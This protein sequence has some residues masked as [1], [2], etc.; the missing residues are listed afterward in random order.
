M[1]SLMTVRQIAERYQCSERTARRYMRRMEHMENPL[2]VTEQAVE[3]WELER[4]MAI[5]YNM[6]SIRKVKP[7]ASSGPIYISRVRE[8]RT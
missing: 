5:C 8:V 6:P 7:K 1:K 2:R 3:A 4:T